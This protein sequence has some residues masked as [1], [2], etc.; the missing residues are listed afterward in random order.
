[1]LVGAMK[2]HHTDCPTPATQL[3]KMRARS[4]KG[5]GEMIINACVCADHLPAVDQLGP[6]LRR[7][8]EHVMGGAPNWSTAEVVGVPLDSSEAR[9]FFKS[10]GN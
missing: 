9:D 6:G 1:M 3:V 7:A 5:W 4:R 2:C 8:L 10:K